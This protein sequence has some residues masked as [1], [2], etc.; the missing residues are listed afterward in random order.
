MEGAEGDTP[1]AAGAAAGRPRRKEARTSSERGTA[2]TLSSSVDAPPRPP[3]RHDRPTLEHAESSFASLSVS[4]AS[5]DR[6]IEVATGTGAGDGAMLLASAD[7]AAAAAEEEDTRMSTTLCSRQV[8]KRRHDDYLPMEGEEIVARADEK[9]RLLTNAERLYHDD[10]ILGAYRILE[11]LYR[12][13][14]E[15]LTSPLHRRILREGRLCRDLVSKLPPYAAEDMSTD[16]NADTDRDNGRW[17]EH[18][19]THNNRRF[20]IRHRFEEGPSGG[21]GK[22]G[23]GGTTLHARM[24]CAI[25]SDLL[26]PL[27]SVLNET[28]LYHTWLPDWDVPI[29]LK[30]RRSVKLRQTGRCSQV[31]LL[32]MDVPWPL[33]PREAVLR[34]LA[35]DDIDETGTIVIRLDSLNT[36]D[37]DGLVK[38]PEDRGAVRVDF[39]GGFV[40]RK[41][42]RDHPA[43]TTA[44]KRKRKNKTLHLPRTAVKD[45]MLFS[46][47]DNTSTCTSSSKGKETADNMQPRSKNVLGDDAETAK[48][49]ILVSFVMHSDARATALPQSITSFVVGTAIGTMW[50]K[51]IRVAEDVRDDKRPR[52]KSAITSKRDVLYDWVEERVGCMLS[53]LSQAKDNGDGCS[54]GA[55]T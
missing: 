11:P 24:D 36:G 26:L 30:V 40:F 7:L 2:V 33:A 8:G 41:C 18:H 19:E 16:A 39:A 21:G 17:H 42:P 31:L 43:I 35:C 1:A 4:I 9:E 38:E 27:L 34:A 20:V 13:N 14:P 28:D 10:R 32:T 15:L 37:E 29:R 49:M 12:S 25:E 55:I 54:K 44:R 23:R 6:A 46:N 5:S 45:H 48:E 53:S 3:P 22:R 52:H 47:H 51:F 50:S